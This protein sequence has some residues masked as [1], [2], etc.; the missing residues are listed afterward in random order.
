MNGIDGAR[1]GRSIIYSILCFRWAHYYTLPAA[2]LTVLADTLRL[3]IGQFSQILCSL[4]CRLRYIRNK[5]HHSWF[6][7]ERLLR[8]LDAFDQIYLPAACHRVRIICW[9]RRSKCTLR[10]MYGQCYIK[11]FRQVQAERGQDS[12]DSERLRGSR[13]CRCLW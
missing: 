10:C 8:V 13:C 9:E 5:M 7:H 4:R 3:D 2:L 6:C 1:Y 11:V 12:R